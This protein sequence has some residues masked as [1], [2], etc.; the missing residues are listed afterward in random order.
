MLAIILFVKSL[1]SMC[2]KRSITA[3]AANPGSKSHSLFH[4]QGDLTCVDTKTNIQTYV[5]MEQIETWLERKK[6]GMFIR[7]V[8]GTQ[9]DPTTLSAGEDVPVLLQ[10]APKSLSQGSATVLRGLLDPD[11]EGEFLIRSIQ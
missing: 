2:E 3:F 8:D 11:L 1:S 4:W 7:R 5:T 9:S 6:I 10:Q